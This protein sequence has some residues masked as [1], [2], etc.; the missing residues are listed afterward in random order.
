MQ[1]RRMC[2]AKCHKFS[3]VV[4]ECDIDSITLAGFSKAGE[5]LLSLYRRMEI[6]N[7]LNLT[8]NATREPR[9]S[10]YVGF[11]D[12]QISKSDCPD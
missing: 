7:H 11:L 5:A 9:N 12:S 1:S 8:T 2:F 3:V 4:L 6:E 10:P